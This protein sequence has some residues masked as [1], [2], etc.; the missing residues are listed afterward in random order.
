M[1]KSPKEISQYSQTPNV[2]KAHYRTYVTNWLYLKCVRN[3]N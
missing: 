3:L 1:V 2:N